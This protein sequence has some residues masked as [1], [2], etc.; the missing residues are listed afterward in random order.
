MSEPHKRYCAK[1]A[2]WTRQQLYTVPCIQQV[3]PAK[4]SLALGVRTVAGGAGGGTWSVGYTDVHCWKFTELY[5][6]DL[7][8]SCRYIVLNQSP[9]KKLY[10]RC[11]CKRVLVLFAK[12]NKSLKMET[13]QVPCTCKVKV[14][15]VQTFSHKISK[16]WGFVY[17]MVTTVDDGVLYIWGLLRELILKIV[18]TRKNYIVHLKLV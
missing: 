16:S 12:S 9:F 2:R 8:L 11:F 14:T 10:T 15:G 1:I 5:T 3:N 13:V 18:I 6:W 4:E 7:C 17:S